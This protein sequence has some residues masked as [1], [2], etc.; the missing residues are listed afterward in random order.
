MCQKED[1][2]NHKPA[3][4]PKRRKLAPGEVENETASNIIGFLLLF[5][6]GYVIYIT[7]GTDPVLA[8]AKEDVLHN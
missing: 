7:R 8:I 3:C 6:F 5:L 2:K 1:W 4:K